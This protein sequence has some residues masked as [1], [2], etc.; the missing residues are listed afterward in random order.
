MQGPSFSA[1]LQQADAGEGDLFGRS[2]GVAANK[3][4]NWAAKPASSAESFEPATFAGQER[5]AC[6]NSQ[7]S[8]PSSIDA[9]STLLFKPV[10]DS[11]DQAGDSG[12]MVSSQQVSYFGAC[13]QHAAYGAGG[14]ARGP[15][16]PDD[17]EV[18][19]RVLFSL[20]FLGP[21]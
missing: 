10:G 18:L 1:V 4:N 5:V 15:V 2:S 17:P 14:R 7:G 8:Q 16:S 3:N 21:G 9:L 20:D 19:P 12:G 6:S 11:L 13:M